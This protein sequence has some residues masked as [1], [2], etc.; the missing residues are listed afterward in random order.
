MYRP[1]QLRRLAVHHR[2]FSNSSLILQYGMAGERGEQGATTSTGAA[3]A[4]SKDNTM[5]EVKILMLHG[6]RQSDGITNLSD[7]TGPTSEAVFSNIPLMQSA[8]KW[9]PQQGAPSRI[10]VTHKLLSRASRSCYYSEGLADRGLQATH[11]P[12]LYFA[13]KPAPWRSSSPNPLRRQ[14]SSQRSSTQRR[15]PASAPRTSLGFSLPAVG[16]PMMLAAA[17][18]RRRWTHGRGFAR[19]RPA[20]ITAC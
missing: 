8:T 16:R 12:D 18:T 4:G 20:V 11:N 19:T 1:C 7:W 10:L 5:R 17:P 6:K 9:G 13:P 14:N 2:K 3:E 15:P